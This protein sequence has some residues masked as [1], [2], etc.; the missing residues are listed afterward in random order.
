[1]LA[2]A[3]PRRWPSRARA[4]ESS[5]PVRHDGVGMDLAAQLRTLGAEAEF[6][7]AD[8]R[9]ED[10]VHTLVLKTVERF[11]QLDVAVNNAGDRG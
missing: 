11:G 10:D 2:S 8:V 1:M 5:F 7:R 6:I 9:Y 4:P 3:A